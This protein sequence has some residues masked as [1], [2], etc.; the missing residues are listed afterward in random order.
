MPF[1]TRLLDLNTP[2]SCL[3]LCLCL[4]LPRSFPRQRQLLVKGGLLGLRCLSPSSLLFHPA[5]HLHGPACLLR[6]PRFQFI[7]GYSTLWPCWATQRFCTKVPHPAYKPSSV[8][9]CSSKTPDHLLRRASNVASH[10]R[11][12]DSLP[13]PNRHHRRDTPTAKLRAPAN[14]TTLLY[15]RD[16]PTSL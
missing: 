1:S 11:T 4:W 5:A 14:H 7:S 8:R 10:P 13:R 2:P 9:P 6:V 3:C 12:L 16:S 15:Q